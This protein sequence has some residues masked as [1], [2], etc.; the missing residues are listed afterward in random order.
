M[1]TDLGK[2]TLQQ[3][4]FVDKYIEECFSG[5]EATLAAN[6]AKASAGYSEDYPVSRILSVVKDEIVK[7]C[8]DQLVMSVPKAIIEVVGVLSDPAKE[9]SRRILEAATLLLDRGGVVKKE[10][11]EVEVKS[12]NGIVILPAKQKDT[13]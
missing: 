6:I 5:T 2:Y 9:G 13:K 10:H 11:V 4:T 8:Q 12:D 3:E 1:N 7:R